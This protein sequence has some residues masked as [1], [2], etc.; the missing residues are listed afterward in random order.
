M[1][2]TIINL[3]NLPHLAEIFEQLRRGRHL[4]VFDA[5]LYRELSEHDVQFVTI[6]SALGFELKFHHRDFYYFHS[7]QKPSE[8]ATR[9]TLFVFILVEWLSNR[10]QDVE[11]SL[12][13]DIFSIDDLPHF[14]NERHKRIMNEAGVESNEDLDR[15]I[16]QLDRFGYVVRTHAGT[17][18]RFRPP[19]CRFLDICL[20]VLSEG[21]IKV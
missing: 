3:A 8:A 4:C 20:D 15:V 17:T 21:E 2:D 18:F 12:L 7:R 19:V 9:M 13:C 10:G 16:S 11:E 14:I 5:E 6:F 1:S